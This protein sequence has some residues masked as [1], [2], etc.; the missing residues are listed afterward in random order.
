M[1]EELQLFVSKV[2]GLVLIICLHSFSKVFD[3]LFRQKCSEWYQTVKESVIGDALTEIRKLSPDKIEQARK[4][5]KQLQGQETSL[6][7]TMLEKALSDTIL[8]RHPT[9]E[10]KDLQLTKK[11]CNKIGREEQHLH[12]RWL[13]TERLPATCQQKWRYH[14]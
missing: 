11:N 13:A 3:Y 9:I 6:D 12:V 4:V 5:V 14:S 7:Y 1:E 2:T 8:F 10:L